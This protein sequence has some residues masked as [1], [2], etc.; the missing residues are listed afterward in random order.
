MM[1]TPSD[2]RG[3]A[4]GSSEEKTKE[5]LR[6]A[7]GK[8]L[9]I[10]EAYGFDGGSSLNSGSGQNYNKSV[11]PPGKTWALRHQPELASLIYVSF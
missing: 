11:S 10:D 6:S 9:V 2:F 8:V 3:S 7:M 1:R 5:L 4:I